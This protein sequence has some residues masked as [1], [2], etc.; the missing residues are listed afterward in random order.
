M[1]RVTAAQEVATKQDGT[2]G[3]HLIR[4]GREE[5]GPFYCLSRGRPTTAASAGELVTVH[6]QERMSKLHFSM[7]PWSRVPSFV[8]V[9]GGVEPLKFCHLD[10]RLTILPQNRH[11]ETRYPSVR[12][13]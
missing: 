7:Y 8:A 13:L 2:N 10:R 4:V 6:R 1:L 12:F 3:I 11:F 9:A 5:F